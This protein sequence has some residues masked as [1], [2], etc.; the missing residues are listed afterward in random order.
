MDVKKRLAVRWA[1]VA[2]ALGLVV[3]AASVP[4]LANGSS[5]S[6][7]GCGVH[8]AWTTFGFDNARSGVNPCETTL[9]S[10]T[11]PGLHL[12]WSASLNS[13]SIAQ[14]TY[15]P[16]L[17]V[18]GVTHDVLFVADEH[19]F[20]R[21]LDAGSG[22]LL[23]RHAFGVRKTTCAPDML[24]AKFGVSGAPV[25]DLTTATGYLLGGNDGLYAIDLTTG[26][27]RRGWRPIRIG[28]SKLDHDWGALTLAGGTIYATLASYCDKGTYYGRVVAVDIATHAVKATWNVVD[29]TSNPGQYAG[30]IWGYGGVSVDNS[31]GAVYA[32]TGNGIPDET[33]GYSDQ[34]V[35]LDPNLHVT[36]HNYA[37]FTGS[38]VDYGATP[39]L[40][41]PPGCPAML[42]AQNKGGALVIYNRDHIG[43]G[44]MQ[45]IQI[46]NSSDLGDGS[47][48]GVPS[49]SAA[50]NMVYV[51]NS[52]WSDDNTYAPGMVALQV[53]PGCTLAKAWNDDLGFND[54]PVS[55]ATVANGVVYEGDG[56]SSKLFA[57]NAQTGTQLWDSGDTIGGSLYAAPTVVDGRVFAVAW[58]KKVY[59]FGT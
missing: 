5:A 15:A 10:A 20:V 30:G 32:A 4:V 19:G 40:F 25:L 6:A 59:A 53:Q 13:V 38:D 48:V 26:K 8:T 1:S 22:Q 24:D 36:D 18:R 41:Q 57:F 34:I 37:G 55:P 14:P 9:G 58:N 11:V 21:A 45:R 35:R 54:Q 23:W 3:V 47:F 51:S 7:S 43:A 56:N 49:Y 29:P 16:G 44:P 33:A 52:S 31:N 39:L 12:L 2:S 46:A 17:V 28:N 27:P 42:A 50:T